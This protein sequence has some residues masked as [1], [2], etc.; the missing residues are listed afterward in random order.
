LFK[1]IVPFCTREDL[2]FILDR[3]TKADHTKPE[4]IMDGNE[5]IEAQQL[6]REVLVAGPV[7]DYAIRL[8]LA[9]H[10]NNEF[11]LPITNRYVRCGASPR[12][13]QAIILTAKVQAL[14]ENRFNVSF[15]DIR[16]VYLLALRH[17]VLLNFEAQ[18][19]SLSTDMVLSQILQE[20]P[21][22]LKD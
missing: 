19:E 12:G 6:I 15:G 7:Q 3:T 2:N 11:A 22:V 21:E 10:P 5:I 13:V 17:R 1:L 14:L 18:A 20:V 9:T 16:K 8:L 4:K